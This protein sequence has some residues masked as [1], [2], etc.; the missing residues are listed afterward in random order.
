MP[1]P[2]YSAYADTWARSDQAQSL[3]EI[4]PLA[5]TSTITSSITI[6]PG[7]TANIR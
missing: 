3:R 2:S 4:P 1:G 6:L 7:R 5:R